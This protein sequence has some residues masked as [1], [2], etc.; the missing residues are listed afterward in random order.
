MIHL[1]MCVAT[2]RYVA[3]D[4]EISSEIWGGDNEVGMVMIWLEVT[5]LTICLRDWGKEERSESELIIN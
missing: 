2:S 4:D 1:T 5:A 3:S